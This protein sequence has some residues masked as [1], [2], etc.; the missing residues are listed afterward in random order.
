M[1]ACGTNNAEVCLFNFVHVTEDSSIDALAISNV[2]KT[3]G[4]KTWILWYETH[5]RGRF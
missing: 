5:K 2:I 4:V 1:P 3:W